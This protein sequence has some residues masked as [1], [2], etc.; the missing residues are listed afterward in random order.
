MISF[1]DKFFN[2]KVDD[3]GPDLITLDEVLDTSEEFFNEAVFNELFEHLQEE[4]G[5]VIW[6]DLEIDHDCFSQI[7][8][9]TV[10]GFGESWKTLKTVEEQRHYLRLIV[11]QC[12]EKL[13]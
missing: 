7:E 10:S 11:V 5:G 13:T 3:D 9:Q 2:W 8:E 6:E 4:V 1:F 12:I